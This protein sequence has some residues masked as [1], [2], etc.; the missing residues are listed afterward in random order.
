MQI[1]DVVCRLGRT[2]RLLVV[3]V[4]G[5]VVIVAWKPAPWRA[6]VEEK[7]HV[8]ALID[9]EIEPLYRPRT[10]GLKRGN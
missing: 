2:R 6:P 4:N 3:E 9:K 10:F 8:S 1:G 5:D 7:A